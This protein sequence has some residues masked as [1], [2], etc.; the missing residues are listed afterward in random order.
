MAI[1][2]NHRVCAEICEALG[3][4]PNR[5][6]MLNLHMAVDKIV[7]VTARI[8]VDPEQMGKAVHILKR[9][10]LEEKG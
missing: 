5:T 7:T 10:R 8:L 3:L 1:S 4:D 2:G 9:F 6:Q